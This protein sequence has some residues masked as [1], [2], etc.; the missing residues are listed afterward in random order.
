VELSLYGGRHVIAE[1]GRGASLPTHRREALGYWRPKAVVGD[2]SDE[3][4]WRQAVRVAREARSKNSAMQL[5]ANRYASRA[6]QPVEQD[7]AR[8]TCLSVA[9]AVYKAHNVKAMTHKQV[10]AAVSEM[11]KPA[12]PAGAGGSTDPITE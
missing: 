3:S 8:I 4:A 6:G 9:R 7:S 11:V 10:I 2:P 12:A 5:M 1:L